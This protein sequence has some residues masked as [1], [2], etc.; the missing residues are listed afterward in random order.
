MSS[1]GIFKDKVN[2]V[3]VGVG[4]QGLITFGRV[5]GETCIRRG[6]D[7]R[8]A[9]THGMS[10]RG[11]AVEVFVR[12]GYGVRAPLVSP[13]QA[14][15]VVATEV[16]EALRGVRYLKKCGWILISDIILPPP[17]AKNVPLPEDI[18]TALKKL[19]INVIQV[20][21]DAITRKVG[22]VRTMNMAML[23]GLVAFIESLLPVEVVAEVIEN[24]LGYI[25]KEAFLM[26]YEE[27]KNKKSDNTSTNNKICLDK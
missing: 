14:D 22:D 16:L 23:G 27:V 13:G 11:G 20:P 4:G 15:Y 6:I 3:I 2:I 17:L 7:I 5:L 10:Q 9:E 19:P 18:I 21:A 8:I 1:Q 12:I 25:N 26:G 24:M